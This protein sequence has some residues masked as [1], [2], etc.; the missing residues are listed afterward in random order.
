MSGKTGFGVATLRAA[1]RLR[2]EQSS[3]RNTAAEIGMSY[4]GLRGFLRGGTPQ[5]ETL[6]R[7]VAWYARSRSRGTAA[8]PPRDVE[9]AVVLLTRYIHQAGTPAQVRERVDQLVRTL[10][11]PSE[12]ADPSSP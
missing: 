5:P 6:R 4:T 11:Q 12:S 8:I 1:A 9:A 3:L 7:L 10:T 2:A